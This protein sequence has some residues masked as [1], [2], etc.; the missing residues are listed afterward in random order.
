M[1][2]P[3]LMSQKGYSKYRGCSLST[4]QRAINSG[5]ISAAIV[6]VEEKKFINQSKADELWILN[7]DPRRA[8]NYRGGKDSDKLYTGKIKDD[9]FT[10]NE[11]DTKKKGPD[12]AV[13]RAIREAYAARMAKLTFEKQAGKLVQVKEVKDYMM[14]LHSRARDSLLNLP[15]KLGPKLASEN[16]IHKII[17]TLNKEIQIVCDHFSK[18]EIDF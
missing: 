13:N 1:T 6:Q 9:E 8:N 17:E 18:G 12:F 4:V 2:K 3:I 16:D 10:S 14:K 5:R 11:E 15:D 7:T